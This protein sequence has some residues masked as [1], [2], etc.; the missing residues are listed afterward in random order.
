MGWSLLGVGREI[1]KDLDDVA[2]A[3]EA[4]AGWAQG[5]LSRGSQR[6][7]GDRHRRG[8]DDDGAGCQWRRQRPGLG[9]LLHRD[10]LRGQL[11]G[12]RRLHRLQG[13]LGARQWDTRC[14]HCLGPLGH[15]QDRDL[16]QGGALARCVGR[17]DGGRAGDGRARGHARGVHQDIDGERGAG[18]EVAA[19]TRQLA[20]AGAGAVRPRGRHAGQVE[21]QRAVAVSDADVSPKA[22]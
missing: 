20:R 21:G 19:R 13:M 3:L 8:A 18:I 15:H 1:A 17:G 16:A 9:L 14:G 7:E 11:Q 4:P 22:R 5:R 10:L 12:H 6:F 2:L